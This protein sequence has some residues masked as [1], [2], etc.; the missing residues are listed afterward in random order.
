MATLR[1][2]NSELRHRLRLLETRSSTPAPPHK[3]LTSPS[4]RS[5]MRSASPTSGR[6]R[7]ADATALPDGDLAAAYRRLRLQH[8]ATRAQLRE[9]SSAFERL[10]TEA[11][12]E[13]LVWRRRAGGAETAADR[14]MAAAAEEGGGGGT[15]GKSKGKLEARVARLQGLL[16]RERADR[17][18]EREAHRRAMRRLRREYDHLAQA[19]A[20][21]RESVRSSLSRWTGRAR[22]S[23]TEAPPRAASLSLPRRAPGRAQHSDVPRS[24]PSPSQSSGGVAKKS[25]ASRRNYSYSASPTGGRY[26]SASAAAAAQRPWGAGPG[27]PATSG[28]TGV[29]TLR[30]SSGRFRSW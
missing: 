2:E 1:R 4:S 27:S 12:K 20:H 29:G 10:R 14:S 19:A 28:A 3:G 26:V 5:P 24:S 15:S 30:G 16:L 25:T 8:D 18:R 6:T 11:S 21:K 17:E 9:L 22:Q 23:L 13:L 7:A